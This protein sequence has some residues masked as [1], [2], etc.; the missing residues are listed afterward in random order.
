[1]K[2]LNL[3][4]CAFGPYAGRTEIPLHKFGSGGLF[5][6]CGATGAGKTTIFD[7]ITFALYGEASGSTRTADTLRSDFADPSAKTFVD[8]TFTHAGK[9]YRVVRNPRYL[10]PKRKGGMTTENA[11][12][13]LTRPD[14]SVCSGASAVTRE[15]VQ[16]LG[17]DCKQF[18]QTSMIAQGEFLKLLL[19]DSAE[20]SDIFRRV[21]DTGLY[22]R[23]QDL[24][25][26]RSQELSAQMNENAR[27]ILQ[28]AGA[29]RPDGNFLTADTLAEFS[30]ENDVHLAPR[31]LKQLS[32]SIEAERK[33]AEQVSVGRNAARA[34]T[35]K[36]A[37][38]IAAAEQVNRVFDEL[39]STK[40]KALGLKELSQTMANTEA[41]IRAAEQAQAQVSPARDAFLREKESACRLKQ[42]VSEL[43][44]EISRKEKELSEFRAAAQAEKAKEPYRL[45]LEGKMAGLKSELPH[46]EKAQAL[47]AQAQQIKKELDSLQKKLEEAKKKQVRLETEQKELEAELQALKDVEVQRVS[48]EADGKTAA[49][50]CEKLEE[51]IT[52]TDNIL[53]LWKTVRVCQSAYPKAEARFQEADRKASDAELLFLREQAGLM[54]AN[55]KD[56]EPCP[57]CGSASH[58][59][60][61]QLTGKAPSGSTLKRL[62]D[63]R[64][65]QRDA[66]HKAALDAKEAKTKLEADKANLLSAAAAVLGS[67]T[68]CGSVKALRKTAL[69]ALEKTCVQKKE[70]D[71][72]L[73]AL[74]QQSKRKEER[75]A[76]QNQIQK[77]L[78]SSETEITGLEKKQSTRQADWKAV[79]AE[80]SA[81][82][83][84]LSCNS[85]GEARKRLAVCSTELESMKSAREKA[86]HDFHDCEN[87]LGAA[88]AVLEDNRKSLAFSAEQAQK[89]QKKYELRLQSAGFPCE[90]DYLNALIPAE[91]LEKL[92]KQLT[93]YRDQ[94]CAV[95]NDLTRLEKETED[96]SPCNLGEMNA[97]L[98][99]SHKREEKCETALR[100]ISVRLEANRRA[101]E[102]MTAK[103]EE[104]K[105]LERTYESV[106][107]LDKTANGALT[108]RQR[109]NFEQFVQAAYFNRILEQAN[110]RLAKMTGGRYLLLR[111]ETASDLRARFGLDI[112]VLDHYTGKVRDIKSLSGGESFKASLSLALGL[113]DVVQ[114][115]SGGV[116][117]ETMFVDEG[118]GTL[119]DESRRQAISTLA[120]LAGG[121]RLVGIISHVPELREQIDRQIIVRR[122]LTGSTVQIVS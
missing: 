26:T 111:R 98:S 53:I 82:Q 63:E 39:K 79:Q 112:D 103:L 105:K 37:A 62:K 74:I 31:M 51:I 50:T 85:E 107:D 35:E 44:V 61:A 104:R 15:I 77:L 78:S 97:L 118:F 83:E 9:L 121:D 20:R 59:A 109:L 114:S 69:D 41:K 88:R 52:G 23:I 19:A 70:L 2:P 40:Q 60:K 94:C 3:V 89:L 122:G 56:G 100:E 1:M 108:G 12:A 33:T 117:I 11:D 120:E 101:A 80:G 73:S 25:R 6:I 43:K 86:E 48:C 72:R 76:R 119:D 8:L 28:D 95:R 90:A 68:G 38:Q 27:A 58:P 110:L 93:D 7:A 30:A 45:E 96:K 32:A 16:L 18:R 92:K 17:I 71:I 10:R 29:I 47:Q 115:R 84:S 116:R 5:L 4:V 57:V 13:A 106:L 49:Q 34:E 64:E 66:L 81:M 67:L 55:L 102:K 36:L 65:R 46:Y 42:A 54:A 75:T 87:S 99:E 91:K 21:F 14:G 113:S 24:L 22:R